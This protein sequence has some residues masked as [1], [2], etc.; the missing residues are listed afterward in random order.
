LHPRFNT[1]KSA[2]EN[3]NAF[4]RRQSRVTLGIGAAAAVTA[5]G[6]SA[7][8][9]AA[10]TA[11]PS[12][13]VTADSKLSA[14][15]I[16]VSA[17]AT[18]HV[19]TPAITR[20]TGPAP[21]L[22]P[23]PHAAAPR[24]TATVRHVASASVPQH[25]AVAAKPA[26]AAHAV[27]ASHPAAAPSH[28]APAKSTPSHSAAPAHAAAAPVHLAAP[29]HAAPVH[30]AAPAAHPAP[31]APPAKPYLIYDSVTPSSIPAGHEVAT[32]ATGGFAVPASHVAGR[33]VLWIDTNGSDP[34]AGALDVEPGDATPS[35]AAAWTQH[36]LSADPNSIAVIYTMQS[37][38]PSV[39]AAIA[40][41]PSSMQ[42]HVRW[43][44]ADPTGVPHL[45]P[46]SSA[47]QWYWG[48]GYDISTASPGF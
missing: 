21:S 13:P 35:V 6:L 28:P 19:S 32:Y 45:V 10:V 20:P 48:P 11:G 4:V 25:P 9:A 2:V 42:S 37:E 34:G 33:K 16:A 39:Q 15:K 41:L 22:A 5:V 23:A 12:H 30:L 18:G 31:P 44:I 24:P 43:W 1:P 40:A 46:G 27:A 17:P 7:G 38:W 47:T 36:K 14:P 8:V 26:P 3:I 29:A